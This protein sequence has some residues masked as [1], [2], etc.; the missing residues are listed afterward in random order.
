MCIK[1]WKRIAEQEATRYREHKAFMKG[2]EDARGT[3]TERCRSSMR[4]VKAV[5]LV[6]AYLQRTNDEH[7]RFF[8]LLFGIDGTPA[9]RGEKGMIALSFEFCVSVSQLYQWKSELLS[10]LLLAAAQTGALLPYRT[11]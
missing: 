10:L 5:D 7:A 1:E 4:W 6:L 11:E 9:Y 2:V 3:V 8:R